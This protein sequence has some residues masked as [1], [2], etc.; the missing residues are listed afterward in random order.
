M[1]PTRKAVRL[2]T[3]RARSKRLCTFHHS[4]T[5]R[6]AIGGWTPTDHP[7]A[8]AACAH[9]LPAAPSRASRRPAKEVN[10]WE[11]SD[12]TSNAAHG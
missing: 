10:G 7:A 5:P 2:R 6:S 8:R 3:N 4:S 1:M 11:R 12:S 9:R